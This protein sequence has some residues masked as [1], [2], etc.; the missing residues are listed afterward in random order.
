MSASPGGDE[1]A[2]LEVCE[3][4]G[5]VDVEVMTEEDADVSEYTHD[6]DVEWNRIQLPDE[7]LEIRDALN[8]VITDRLEKL[9]S[10]AS[11]KSS[12]D[13]SERDFSRFRASCGLMNADKRRAT[14]GCRRT[15]R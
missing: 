5:I 14:R 8:E 3:N 9:K 15:R 7:I 6:T 1:E 12:A 4:L 10:W 13:I 11:R 2:I